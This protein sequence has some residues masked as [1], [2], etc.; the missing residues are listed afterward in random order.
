[1]DKNEKEILLQEIEKLKSDKSVLLN[2]T[3]DLNNLIAELSFLKAQAESFNN[4]QKIF[5]AQ[6][7]HELKTPLNAIL[8]FARLMD[9][10]VYGPIENKKYK[11]YVKY[12]LSAGQTL[13][14]LINNQLNFSKLEMSQIYLNEKNIDLIK[15]LNESIALIQK[16]VI[17]EKRNIFLHVKDPVF[18]K[19]DE[20]M[21]KQIFFNILSNAVKFTKKDGEINIYLRRLPQFVRIIFK[22]NG[23]GIEKNKLKN[24]FDPFYKTKQTFFKSQQGMGLGLVLV[25]KMVILHQ[26]RVMIK[27][28]LNKGTLLMIDFPNER[29]L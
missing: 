10:E 22:D 9:E 29:F 4:S 12:I 14:E 1:M 11:E 7:N 19:A 17:Y 16:A 18:L 24:L 27:S 25:K 6:M 21:I 28:V 20:Q 26:G 8:G 13:F 2:Q 23:C 3:V 5:I 15:V